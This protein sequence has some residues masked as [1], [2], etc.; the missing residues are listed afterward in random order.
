MS[1]YSKF[2]GPG[3]S[4]IPLLKATLL[5]QQLT[6]QQLEE[7]ASHL[8]PRQFSAGITIFHQGMPGSMLYLIEQGSVRVFGVGLTGQEHTF[9]TF[10]AGSIF[11]EL[12]V[13]DGKQRTA[14]AITLE[15]TRVWMLSKENFEQLAEQYPIICRAA[16]EI[17]AS[18]LRTA[19]MH[20]ENIIFQ[21]VL[22][23][24]SFELLNLADRHGKKSDGTT[25]IGLPLTQ[26]D[27]ATIVGATRESVNKALAQLRKEGFLK[28]DGTQ[29][30]ILD[31]AG[32]MKIVQQRGR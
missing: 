1:I 9:N 30:W 3:S 12:S 31:E 10:S 5:F 4:V 6:Q 14:S 8:M 17:L 29:F 20:V 26:T 15:N 24:L 28:M 25:E 11:G 7:V 27:L 32:L 2:S 21:D 18:R 19:A 13:F 16:I 22:G 23:R